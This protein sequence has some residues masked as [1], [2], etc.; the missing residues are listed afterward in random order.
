MVDNVN[1]VWSLIT[2]IYNILHILQ[3]QLP[4]AKR[5]KAEVDSYVLSGALIWIHGSACTAQPVLRSL[6][7][8]SLSAFLQ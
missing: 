2:T 7:I 8:N 1:H 5:S 3:R 6:S 4:L